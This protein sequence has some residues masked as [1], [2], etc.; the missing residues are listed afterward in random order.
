MEVVLKMAGV[1]ATIPATISALNA[2]KMEDG[3]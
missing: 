3:I 2:M 1:I